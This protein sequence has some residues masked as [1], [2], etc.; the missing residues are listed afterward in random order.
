MEFIE[1]FLAVLVPFMVVVC[2]ARTAWVVNIYDSSQFSGSTPE[3][4]IHLHQEPS[5]E[6]AKRW[7]SEFIAAHMSEEDK[8]A[9]QLDTTSR[10][11]ELPW[12]SLVCNPQFDE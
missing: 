2:P 8:A 4:V 7:A 12:E 5:E 10:Q 6:D 9:W 3:P 1:G 11:P